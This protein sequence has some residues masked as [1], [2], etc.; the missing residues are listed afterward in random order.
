MLHVTSFDYIINSSW[1]V[2]VSASGIRSEMLKVEK[3]A[4]Y[5]QGL[6]TFKLYNHEDLKQI[7][8]KCAIMEK[9]VF[10]KSFWHET[11]END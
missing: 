3:L 10:I 6:N 2:E 1:L 9:E 7:A 8:N 5:W 11:I 4:R